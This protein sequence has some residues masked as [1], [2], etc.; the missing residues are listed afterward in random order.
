MWP[1]FYCRTCF[2]SLKLFTCFLAFSLFC[3]GKAV[4][5]LRNRAQLTIFCLCPE[6]GMR[7]R[8]SA[9]GSVT[10]VVGS[11]LLGQPLRVVGVLSLCSVCT[12]F[13][14]CSVHVESSTHQSHGRAHHGPFKGQSEVLRVWV[15]FHF[16]SYIFVFSGREI[17]PR[18]PNKFLLCLI[19]E[20]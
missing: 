17:F 3:T 4:D 10:L 1:E 11:L 20:N 13:C 14:P 2:S 9:K 8:E 19:G 6:E 7:Y 16:F 5:E 15:S 12:Y 18:G